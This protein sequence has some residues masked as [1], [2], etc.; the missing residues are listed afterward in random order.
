MYSINNTCGQITNRKYSIQ[1]FF[2]RSPSPTEPVF[3]GTARFWVAADRHRG[4]YPPTGLVRTI[5]FCSESS[6]SGRRIPPMSSHSDA[7][8][9]I[10]SVPHG[11]GALHGLAE[12]FSPDLFR[13]TGN[14]TLPISLPAG[15]NG[16]TPQIRLAYSTGNGNDPFGLGWALNLKSITGKTDKGLLRYPDEAESD[17]FIPSGDYS[18][19]SNLILH[20]KYTGRNGGGGPRSDAVTAL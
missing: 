2:V 19:I 14:F 13:R 9:Q 5:S 12:T 18:A 16:F 10:I 11:G 1:P 17:A 7:A 8:S 20:I 4:G 6:P 15:R 3:L